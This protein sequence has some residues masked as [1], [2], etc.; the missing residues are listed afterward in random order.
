MMNRLTRML[1][2][3]A[4]VAPLAACMTVPP[5]E[6]PVLIKLEDLDRRLQAIERV[7]ENQSLVQLTQQVDALVRIDTPEE[8]E[9]FRNGGILPYVLRK[10]AK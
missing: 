9:A 7:M 4:L 2:A 5:E 8:L 3:I 10:L 1:A 6:D